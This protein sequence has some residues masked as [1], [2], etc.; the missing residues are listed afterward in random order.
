[1]MAPGPQ[2]QFLGFYLSAASNFV[3]DSNTRKIICFDKHG[4]KFL[5]KSAPAIEFHLFQELPKEIRCKIWVQAAENEARLLVFTEKPRFLGGLHVFLPTGQILQQNAFGAY[6][7]TR[8]DRRP[9]VAS[10]SHEALK[11]LLDTGVYKPGFATVGATSRPFFN[12]N[13]DTIRLCVDTM[14]IRGHQPHLTLSM[15]L[16][17]PMELANLTRLEFP[18]ETFVKY[19]KWAGEN[20]RE[21]ANLQNVV[22]SCTSY[23][24]NRYAAHPYELELK[25]EPQW[26]PIIGEDETFE[27]EFEMMPWCEG[28]NGERLY[29]LAA[30]MTIFPYLRDCACHEELM[31]KWGDLSLIANTSFELPDT[32]LK[33]TFIPG[34]LAH[35]A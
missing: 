27:I 33:I 26:T 19:S 35:F 8:A 32:V 23:D 29:G 4:R 9:L 15:T 16:E 3:I 24:W 10:S 1:M 14:G 6:F 13:V 5:D 17:N 11:V 30:M 21:L 28:R 12:P 2:N 25:F 7:R 34:N 22:L 20:L 31:M 18:Y